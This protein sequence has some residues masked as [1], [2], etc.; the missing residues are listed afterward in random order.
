MNSHSD[1]TRPG[2]EPWWESSPLQPA[3]AAEDE[4]TASRA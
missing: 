2:V 3:E 4:G 1:Y